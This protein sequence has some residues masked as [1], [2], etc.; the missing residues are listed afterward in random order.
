MGE[1]NTSGEPSQTA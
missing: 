1:L